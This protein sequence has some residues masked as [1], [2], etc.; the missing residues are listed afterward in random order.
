MRI[1]KEQRVKE[2]LLNKHLIAL[3]KHI[4]DA[5]RDHSPKE[6]LNGMM[7][8][9]RNARKELTSKHKEF[10]LLS[11][12]DDTDEVIDADMYLEGPANEFYLTEQTVFEHLQAV[13]DRTK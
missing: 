9:L 6:L 8:E 4:N 11:S 7:E 10:L 12:A 1:R 3:L 2:P 13:S 5:M